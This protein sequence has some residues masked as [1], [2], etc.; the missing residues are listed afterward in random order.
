MSYVPYASVV[1]ILMY[2]MVCTRPNI[3]H[4]V[5]VLALLHITDTRGSNGSLAVWFILKGELAPV[6]FLL[7]LHSAYSLLTPL[8][9]FFCKTLHKPMFPQA[10]SVELKPSCNHVHMTLCSHNPSPPLNHS[11]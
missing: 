6:I 7:L 1:S 3:A 8:P 4:A 9:L 2:A 5:G 11:R 10:P